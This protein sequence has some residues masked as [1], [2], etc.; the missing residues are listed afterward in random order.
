MLRAV[1]DSRHDYSLRRRSV[2]PS[3]P[4]GQ[5]VAQTNTLAEPLHLFFGNTEATLANTSST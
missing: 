2:T 1:D 5:L 4:A 3:I